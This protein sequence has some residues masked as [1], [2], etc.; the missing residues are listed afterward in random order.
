MRPAATPDHEVI[1]SVAGFGG[2][3]AA[4]KLREIGVHDFLIVSAIPGA[5]LLGRPVAA[6]LEPVFHFGVGGLNRELPLQ[7]PPQLSNKS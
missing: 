1:I 6:V 5:R 7:A 3:C 4:I 2:I